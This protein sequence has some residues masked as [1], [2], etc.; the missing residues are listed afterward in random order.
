M[1]TTQLN[2][3][4]YGYVDQ[5]N[6]N[7]HY[8]VTPSSWYRIGA[9]E[10]ANADKQFLFQFSSFP[11]SLKRKNLVGA[12]LRLHLRGVA[13]SYSFD[14]LFW[15]VFSTSFNPNTVTWNN[16]PS[17]SVGGDGKV[18]FGAVSEA[19]YTI[20]ESVNTNGYKTAI[21]LASGGGICVRFKGTP[22]N[23]HR[24]V[25]ELRA[26]LNNNA[27]PYIT[28]TY[29][30]TNVTSKIEYRS[31]PQSGYYN[32]R[33]S[34]TFSW[35]YV[36]ANSALHALDEVFTQASATFY[37]KES[38]DSDYTSV[39]ISGTTQNVTIAANTFPVASTIQWYV[40]GTD[41]DGTTTSTS[42]Y[43]FSTAASTADAKALA[44]LNTVEDG[45]APITFQWQIIS[46][47]GQPA[48][49]T[50]VWWKLPT[51]DNQHW[52]VLVDVNEA[53]TSFTAPGGTFPAG[54]IQWKVQAFNVDGTEGPWDAN[55]PNPKTFICVSAPQPVSGLA[56]T[57]VPFS[58]ITWQSSEQQAFQISIDGKVVKKSFGADIYSFTLDDP[59]ENGEHEI[60]VIVQG[61]YG[62]WS[63]PSTVTITV[64][65]IP[66]N[67]ITLAGLFDVDALLQWDVGGTMLVYRD[68]ARIAKTNANTFTDRLTLGTHQYYVVE[69]LDNG[70]YNRS[71]T[72][73]GTLSVECG[74][75]APLSGGDWVKLEYSKLN[76]V[77]TYTKNRT[78]SAKHYCGAKYPVVEMSN[79][80]DHSGS[81]SVLFQDLETAESFI[82][83]LGDMVIIKSRNNKV[84]IGVFSQ[85]DERV[86]DFYLDYNFIIQEADFEDYINEADG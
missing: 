21:A 20:P 47:D 15:D 30:D 41:T 55:L 14:D 49:R 67:T 13:A 24:D 83:L 34:A 52:H 64:Q 2:A 75:I 7:T 86:E 57:S 39:E 45:A 37:W 82:A 79:F 42:V 84:I 3:V 36:K 18:F 69:R 35:A 51:E 6:P 32:P 4:S 68:G 61:V 77:Q 70:N 8:S 71:N 40:R 27:A 58:N 74:Y 5:A 44:P 33:N 81:Y 12:Q 62:Y 28:I 17:V 56:A 60:T 26:L 16:K 48:S 85:Y 23:E 22:T 73:V 76:P 78:V 29:D 46:A 9:D 38:T 53:I 11:S 19:D 63:Q 54:E 72:V 65:N 10:Q 31:G 80:Y 1:A 59:L 66:D 50:R 25:M 43:S